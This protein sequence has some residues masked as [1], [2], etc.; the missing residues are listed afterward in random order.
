LESAYAAREARAGTNGGVLARRY[1]TYRKQVRR[2]Y[3]QVS[4]RLPELREILDAT[5]SGQ[6][7]YLV[8]DFGKPFTANGFGSKFREWCD[9][10]GLRH[11]T[12]HGLRK[13]GATIA[14]ENGAT[15]HQLMALF[16][17]T[18]IRQA[19]TYTRQANRE[20]MARDA[21]PPDRARLREQNGR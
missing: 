15:D 20:R 13:A 18:N 10:A 3:G 7:T 17:W 11:C 12:S 8:T 2:F 21:N 5:P 4:G 14:A 1:E 6:L 16:G 19:Q 9:H